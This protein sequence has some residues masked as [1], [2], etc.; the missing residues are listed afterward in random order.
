M[1]YYYKNMFVFSRRLWNIGGGA[2]RNPAEFSSWWASWDSISTYLIAFSVL[3]WNLLLVLVAVT[4]CAIDKTS[5]T[6]EPAPT[7][8][9]PVA[10]PGL[11][12][13]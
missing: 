10:L 13:N 9:T 8:E 7:E 2:S 11:V 1:I 5:M 6:A 3:V 12:H 4:A